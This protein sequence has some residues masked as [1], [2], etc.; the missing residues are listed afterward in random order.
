[1]SCRRTIRQGYM[2]ARSE[3]SSRLPAAIVACSPS[4]FR[5]FCIKILARSPS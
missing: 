2:E 5:I 4:S 3:A 1:M